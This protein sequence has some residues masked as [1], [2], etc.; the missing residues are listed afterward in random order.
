[1]RLNE[2]FITNLDDNQR[3]LVMMDVNKD[4]IV[5]GPA[6][7]GKT[8]LAIH[9]AAQ[10]D[11]FGSFAI[12]VYTKALKRM[13]EFGLQAA[14]LPRDGAVYEWSWTNRGIEIPGDVFYLKNTG[15]TYGID[16]DTLFLKSPDGKVWKYTSCSK[17]RENHFETLYK[18]L[19]ARID[20]LS[21]EERKQKE[22]ELNKFVTIDFADYVSNAIYYTFYRRTRW[23]ERANTPTPGLNLNDESKYTLIG[24]A[25]LYKKKIPV[26]FMIVDEVQDFSLRDIERFKRDTLKS[27]LLLGD[28]LQ[29]VYS[30]RG[31]S[32]DEI[33]SELSQKRYFLTYNYRLPKTIAKVAE[34]VSSNPQN[35][36]EFSKRNNGRSDYPDFPKPVIKKCQSDQEQ[37]DYI[38]QKIT[39]EGLDDVGILLPNK[40]YVK[41]TFNY[42]DEKG[43]DV[44]V[45]FEKFFM[46]GPFR[47]FQQYDTLDFTDPALPS[48]LTL[49]SSKGTQFE[50]VF[51]PF[52]ENGIERNPFYVGLTRSTRTLHLLYS[53]R[54][55]SYLDEVPKDFFEWL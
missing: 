24:S 21:P 6:G 13:I 53:R 9:R 32:M 35:L 14:D 15:A 47:M 18:N 16:P 42:F 25:S 27:Y 52:S 36:V 44:Q 51:M 19:I 30:D 5:Q 1:M 43:I 10:A 46:N 38:Y 20:G 2:W 40:D 37:L 17:N 23:F 55:I 34:K 39:N 48:I 8:I 50:H 45:K 49:H 12:I 4:L 33:T 28:T 11:L 22:K 31:T 26:D 54:L 3:S 29:R 41:T 7:S